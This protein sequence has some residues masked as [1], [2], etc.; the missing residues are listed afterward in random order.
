MPIAAMLGV[1]F[2]SV[3]YVAG[4]IYKYSGFSY[5][6]SDIN[7]LRLVSSDYLYWGVH[8]LID[9]GR[10]HGLLILILYSASLFYM[11]RLFSC[12]YKTQGMLLTS[13]FQKEVA[14]FFGVFLVALFYY[15]LFMI[16]LLVAMRMVVGVADLGR[17]DMLDFIL[18]DRVDNVCDMSGVC[19]EGKV[20]YTGE[21]QYVFFDA[22]NLVGGSDCGYFNGRIKLL[23]KD[24]YEVV[25]G[26]DAD[27]KNKIKG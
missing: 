9:L 12:A 21:D 16:S 26:W 8:A 3:I 6:T 27:M 5:I 24:L 10:M 23:G 2:L 11:H 13:N 22:S 14:R 17:E 1:V 18:S 15:A 25:I 4:F 19:M 7:W 20:F